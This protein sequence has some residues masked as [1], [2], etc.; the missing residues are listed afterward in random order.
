MLRPIYNENDPYAAEWLRRLVSA[1]QIA[2][3]DVD[4]RAVQDLVPDDVVGRP[5]HAF[6]GIGGWSLALRLAGVLD[7]VPIWTGSCPCQPFSVAGRH[8]GQADERHLWP[9]WYELIRECL[10]PVVLGE[11]VASPAGRAW[12]DTVSLDMEALGYAVGA[13]DLCAAS[14]GAPHQR[15]R[16]YFAACLP[17]SGLLADASHRQRR[18]RLAESGNEPEGQVGGRGTRSILGDANG[19]GL[20][21]RAGERE[22]DDAQLPPSERADGA[23][24]GFWGGADWIHCRDD[25]WRPV[26]PGTCPLAYGVSGQVAVVRPGETEPETHWYSRRGSLRCIGNAIVP[27]VAAV[28]I[29]AALDALTF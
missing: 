4:E 19:S 28:F 20:A 9:M 13:A 3:G 15:Q 18:D 7:E 8:R 6:A 12:L 26:E 10:P 5:F 17:S 11:Q 22:D 25:T 2:D 29:A 23:V 27:Q 21:E 1:G 16:L 24:R 14:V